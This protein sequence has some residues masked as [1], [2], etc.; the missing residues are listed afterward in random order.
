MVGLGLHEDALVGQF[1]SGMLHLSALVCSPAQEF[2]TCIR[3]AYRPDPA[4][5]GRLVQLG[6]G[7]KELTGQIPAEQ[8]TGPR[9]LGGA[10]SWSC[11]SWV[12]WFSW[13]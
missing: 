3:P 13:A 4:E 2:I 5:L 8:M 10:W 9:S 1:P 6:L 12:P 7:H 11:G